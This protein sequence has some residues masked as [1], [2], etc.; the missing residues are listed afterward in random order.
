M[1]QRY[2]LLLSC[3]FLLAGCGA[4]RTRAEVVTL[5]AQ[6][7]ELSKQTV[8]QRKQVEAMNNR[9]FIL[10]DRMETVRTQISRQPARPAVKPPPAPKLKIL[11]LQ[12]LPAGHSSGA[13]RLIDSYTPDQE[14]A[15]FVPQPRLSVAA[16]LAQENAAA[17][18]RSPT[19]K[20]IVPVA[21]DPA[22]AYQRAFG[23]L[24]SKDFGGA[25]LAFDRFVKNYPNHDLADNAM[26]WLGECYYGQG[27]HML[28]IQEFRRIPELY[29]NGNKVPDA[30]LKIGFAYAALG[31][32]Q[33][34]R[35]TL[36]Q[37]VE[38]FPQNGA[39]RLAR[40]RLGELKASKTR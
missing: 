33:A 1:L 18:A 37:L 25:I 39:A 13:T 23:L 8:Q 26:Y 12:P 15:A 19:T 9:L 32:R 40:I 16:Q 11:R 21:S 24:K 31:D 29:P 27:E 6:V 22:Q 10:H 28:A 36:K 4:K 14:E 20:T 2:I 3:G 17:E 7:A 5:K 38:A 35:R 34:A 30:L